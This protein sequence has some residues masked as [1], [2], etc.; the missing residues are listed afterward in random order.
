MTKVIKHRGHR[1]R[2]ADAIYSFLCVMGDSILFHPNKVFYAVLIILSML[3]P[4]FS[5]FLLSC[6]LC[7]NYRRFALERIY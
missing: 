4:L 6:M 1:R 3:M 2:F 7:A 5:I